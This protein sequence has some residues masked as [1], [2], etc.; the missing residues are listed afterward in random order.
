[1]EEIAE[2]RHVF[3]FFLNP[4]SYEKGERGGAEGGNNITFKL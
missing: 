3:F 4:G 1:M 2:I